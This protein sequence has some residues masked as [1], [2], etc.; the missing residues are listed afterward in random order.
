MR[1]F[2][3]DMIMDLYEFLFALALICV[4]LW[5]GSGYLDLHFRGRN[6]WVHALNKTFFWWWISAFVSACVVLML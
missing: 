5:V 6:W 3:T 2:G 1:G 4:I